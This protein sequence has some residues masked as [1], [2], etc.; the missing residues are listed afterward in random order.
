[1]EIIQEKVIPALDIV[2]DRYEKEII[3]LPAA[4]QCGECGNNGRA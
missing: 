3:F 2:G 1:M 4:H